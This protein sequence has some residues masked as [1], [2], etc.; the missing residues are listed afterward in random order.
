MGQNR[1]K[2]YKKPRQRLDIFFILYYNVIW[3]LTKCFKKKKISDSYSFGSE[4]V[5]SQNVV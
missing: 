4:I 5:F 1:E 2:N 3:H